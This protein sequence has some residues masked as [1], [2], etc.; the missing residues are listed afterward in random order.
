ML[1][2]ELGSGHRFATV[3]PHLPVDGEEDVIVGRFGIVPGVDVRTGI[4]V[5]IRDEHRAGSVLRH[6]ETKVV[7]GYQVPL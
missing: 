5:M 6:A 1:E 3:R 4:P 2:T 7:L